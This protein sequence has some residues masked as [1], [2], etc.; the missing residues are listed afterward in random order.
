MSRGEEGG[1]AGR[2]ASHYRREMERAI[3]EQK[4]SSERESRE[5][6]PTL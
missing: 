6:E 2:L 4:W 3:R 5:M 1:R